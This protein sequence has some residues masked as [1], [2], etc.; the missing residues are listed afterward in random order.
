MPRKPAARKSTSAPK[1]ELFAAGEVESVVPELSALQRS[2]APAAKPKKAKDAPE[3]RPYRHP[4]ATT[5]LRPE[6]GTQDRL[7]QKK[8]PATYSYDP[9]L[10]PQLMWAGQAERLSLNV[11]TLPLF[12]PDRV[13]AKAIL[14]PLKGHRRSDDEQLSLVET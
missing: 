7:R 12:I 4:E 5:P 10:S 8:E 2:T 11:T 9:S 6:V 14:E 1:P 3:T 13:S